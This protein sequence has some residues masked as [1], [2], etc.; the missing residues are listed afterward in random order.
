MSSPK[1]AQH[2]PPTFLRHQNQSSRADDLLGNTTKPL[3]LGKGS[4]H[5]ARLSLPVL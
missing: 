3:Q 1:L 4:V 5:L 2:L